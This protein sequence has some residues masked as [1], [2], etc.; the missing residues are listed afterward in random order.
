MLH[1]PELSFFHDYLVSVGANLQPKPESKEEAKST[2]V[3]TG[4]GG[5][6]GDGW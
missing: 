4:P 3:G 1:N 2:K 6:E 5:L